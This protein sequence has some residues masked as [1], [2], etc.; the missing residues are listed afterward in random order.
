MSHCFSYHAALVPTNFFIHLV[1]TALEIGCRHIDSV[2]FYRN[3]QKIRDAVHKSGIPRGNVF[4]TTEVMS[5]SEYL[6][7]ASGKCLDGVHTIGE[8]TFLWTPS[9]SIHGVEEKLRSS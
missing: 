5:A 4:L 1:L 7:K 9:L 6:V 2:Q 8:R 3:K